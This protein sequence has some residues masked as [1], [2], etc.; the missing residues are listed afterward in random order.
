MSA[1]RPRAGI[2]LALV[3]LVLVP[4]RPSA[5]VQLEDDES[6]A[7]GHRNEVDEP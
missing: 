1:R 2:A 6:T 4:P 5:G 7:I 3:F